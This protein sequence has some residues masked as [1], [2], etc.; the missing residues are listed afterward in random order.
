MH[1]HLITGLVLT[2]IAL[3]TTGPARADHSRR[4]SRSCDSPPGYSQGVNH[5][6]GYGYGSGYQPGYGYGYGYGSGLPGQSFTLGH[7]FRDLPTTGSYGYRD[8]YAGRYEDESWSSY[9]A[10]S[11]PTYEYSY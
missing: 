1:R 7:E 8:P 9:P 11:Y 6:F 5:R 4:R 3:A 10:Y 2:L